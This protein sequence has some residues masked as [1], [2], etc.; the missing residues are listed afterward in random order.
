MTTKR[1]RFGELAL[2]QEFEFGGRSLKRIS[3]WR[4]LAMAPRQEYLF[5]KSD[6]VN[7]TVTDEKE[8]EEDLFFMYGISSG[9]GTPTKQDD[10]WD[11]TP[12]M[13]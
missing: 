13:P 2:K 8:E 12:F 6:L 4:A 1:I 10:D 3:E 5:K 9:A 7:I 11:D